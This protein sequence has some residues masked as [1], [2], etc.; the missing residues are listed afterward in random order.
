MA[1]NYDNL[2]IYRIEM[3]TAFEQ[4]TSE[5]TA[6]SPAVTRIQ[7]VHF[8]VFCDYIIFKKQVGEL[9]PWTSQKAVCKICC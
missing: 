2:T 4:I 3:N 5:I 6:F 9:E 7:C 1:S 8:V